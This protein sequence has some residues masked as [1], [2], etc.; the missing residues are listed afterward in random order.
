M[1]VEVELGVALGP[2]AHAAVGRPYAA[3]LGADLLVGHVERVGVLRVG[4]Y[5]EVLAHVLEVVCRH[6]H[7]ARLGRFVGRH[8]REVALHRGVQV[9]RVAAVVG[10]HHYRLAAVLRGARQRTAA[11]ALGRGNAELDGVVVNMRRVVGY[12][13]R[14]YRGR[15]CGQRPYLHQ[16]AFLLHIA[17]PPYSLCWLSCSGWE[18][19]IQPR[20]AWV[21]SLCLRT[22]WVFLF[23][24]SAC[25]F[26]RS[27]SM[28]WLPPS[29]NSSTVT[30]NVIG[31]NSGS[32]SG[33]GSGM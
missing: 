25:Y 2:V 28:S 33:L 4:R 32:G 20:P 16:L 22:P 17:V 10:R 23:R 1:G 19:N 15:C 5:A 11:V 31:T 24:S 12:L 18:G 21:A 27:A 29:R 3:A 13:A 9:E 7:A 14:R 8:G 6:G 26:F 30:L